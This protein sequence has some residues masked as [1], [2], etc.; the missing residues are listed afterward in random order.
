MKKIW[1]FYLFLFNVEHQWNE[2]KKIWYFCLFLFNVE[3][4]WNEMKWNEMKWNEKWNEKELVLLLILVQCSR[5][6]AMKWKR[7]GTSTY[8]CSMFKHQCNEMKNSRYF[9]LISFKIHAP[10]KWNEKDLVLLLI[11]VHWSIYN[12]MKKIL[13]LYLFLFYVQET[14]IWNEKDLKIW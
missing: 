13:Y 11:L 8:S 1:Y 4:Q 14:M 7:A 3:H 10:M 2:V 5:T 12:E 6:N 9:Y